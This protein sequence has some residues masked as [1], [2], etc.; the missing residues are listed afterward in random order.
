MPDKPDPV[1][2]ILVSPIKF[3][4]ELVE[5]ALTISTCFSG[6]CFQFLCGTLR[7]PSF[8]RPIMSG[9]RRVGCSEGTYILMPLPMFS[10]L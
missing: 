8:T 7:S 2:Y 1:M 9:I 3:S 6:C 5:M 4:V 10:D